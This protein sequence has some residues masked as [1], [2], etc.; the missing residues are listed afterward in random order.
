MRNS[1]PFAI[2]IRHTDDA[3]IFGSARIPDTAEECFVH[4]RDECFVLADGVPSLP[5]ARE[6]ALLTSETAIWA[7]KVVRQRP[8]YWTEKL[9]LLKR[10]FRS[11]NLTLWQKRR[12]KG[13]SEGLAASLTVLIVI[14]DYF[15]IGSAGNCNAF[16]F[17]EGLIDVLT[18]RDV[19]DEGMITKAAGF[20]RRQL[21]PT[22]H[23][24]RLLR[25]DVLILATDGI[26]DYVSEDEMRSI[27]ETAGVTQESLNVAA[28]LIVTTAKQNGS[29]DDMTV[30][31][32]KRVITG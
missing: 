13:F 18:A 9:E 21:I 20:S 23:S 10:I 30:C 3:I 2:R 7:Y 11:T 26:A 31:V 22:T 27:V 6:A 14:K 16:L 15:W 25:D 29:K 5:H 24:E 12:D 8:F 1:D 32:V 4:F 28:H 19:D 17:R